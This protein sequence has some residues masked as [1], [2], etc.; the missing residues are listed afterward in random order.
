MR[1]HLFCP[2]VGVVKRR[3]AV[4][5]S[6]RYMDLNMIVS[7]SDE[8]NCIHCSVPPRLPDQVWDRLPPEGDICDDWSC[9]L[10]SSLWRRA[11][12]VLSLAEV[13][14]NRTLNSLCNDSLSSARCCGPD[15]V[16]VSSVLSHRIHNSCFDC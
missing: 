11:R 15:R 1:D 5:M 10:L 8:L 4:R 9:T 2:R 6:H 3:L 14:W 7:V 12:P 16:C 13:G